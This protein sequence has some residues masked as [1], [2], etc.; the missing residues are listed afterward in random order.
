MQN[1]VNL[2]RF[3]FLQSPQAAQTKVSFTVY[4]GF[5]QT[6][7]TAKG[8]NACLQRG[9]AKD[10]M[11]TY[12]FHQPSQSAAQAVNLEYDLHHIARHNAQES[13]QHGYDQ[14]AALA[15]GVPSFQEPDPYAMGIHF[16]SVL[17][18]VSPSCQY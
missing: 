15:T 8:S 13:E 4:S 2:H 12:H 6:P 10:G 7:E 11:S 17:G 14:A 16:V 1:C 9:T 3:A 5:Q 18:V